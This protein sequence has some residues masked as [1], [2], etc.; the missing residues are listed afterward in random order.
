MKG[1]K[2]LLYSGLLFSILVI[3]LVVPII[4]LLPTQD[5]E[6][7]EGVEIEIV[8]T[9]L[10]TS[11]SYDNKNNGKFYLQFKYYNDGWHYDKTNKFKAGPR[12]LAR[13]KINHRLK[14]IDETAELY[15]CLFESDFWNKD[16][17]IISSVISNNGVVD[18]IHKGKIC[19]HSVLDLEVFTIE[20]Q[21]G[22]YIILNIINL[23]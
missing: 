23:H 7:I 19:I 18:S 13:P 9:G 6:V 22:D 20:N 5:K 11:E 17:L 14:N 21:K 3:S 1:N 15:V 16:D 12:S 10:Y 2:I 4:L 8:W